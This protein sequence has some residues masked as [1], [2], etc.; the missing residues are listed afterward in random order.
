M[1]F[2]RIAST[3]A[4]DDTA[5]P[6]RA[7]PSAIPRPLET[8][9]SD[10]ARCA[11][12]YVAAA[13]C[14]FRGPAL[15]PY[16]NSIRD[17]PSLR[18]PGWRLRLTRT[19]HLFQRTV[20]FLPDLTDAASGILLA[21][22][23][24]MQKVGLAALADTYGLDPEELHQLQLLGERFFDQLREELVP[25]VGRKVKMVDLKQSSDNFAGFCTGPMAQHVAVFGPLDD[26][27]ALAVRMESSLAFAFVDAVFGTGAV[28]PAA[29][30]DGSERK[31]TS[32]ERNIVENTLGGAL[33]QVAGRIFSSLLGYSEDFRVIRTEN[34]PGLLADSFAASEQMVTTSVQCLVNDRGGVIEL[35]IPLSLIV[36]VKAALVPHRLRNSDPAADHAKARSLLG[37][38]AM[39]LEAVLGNL[40]MPLGEVR[41]L[42]PGSILI[43]RKADLGSPRVELCSGDLVLFSGIVAEHRGWRRFL[44]QDKRGM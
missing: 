9:W 18:I 26:V 16:S 31:I 10:A 8:R 17:R 37:G 6:S 23:P 41:A 32:T 43:L 15:A 20:N 40:T 42:A 35:A 7:I 13:P 21:K 36:R 38:A 1:F 2:L 28:T 14:D 27:A 4:A 22:Q 34:R 24:L 30:A 33:A 5:V 39:E 12:P 11:R 29:R 25:T 3:F 44:I 19:K